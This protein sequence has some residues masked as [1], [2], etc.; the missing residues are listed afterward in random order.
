M[1][2]RVMS[3]APEA[4]RSLGYVLQLSPHHE[5][6]RTPPSAL[7]ALQAQAASLLHPG[8]GAAEPW[9]QQ[10]LCQHAVRMS[11]GGR[12]RLQPKWKSAKAL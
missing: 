1:L 2:V 10:P 12:L 7:P 5:Q 8:G 4:N 6:A 11:G 3:G 9:P